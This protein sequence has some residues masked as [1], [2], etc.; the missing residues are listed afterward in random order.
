MSQTKV[1]DISAI[2]IANAI[3]LGTEITMGIV[4][5]QVGSELNDVPMTKSTVTSIISN[6]LHAMINSRKST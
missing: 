3:E 5:V 1:Q 6:R 2:T 4:G